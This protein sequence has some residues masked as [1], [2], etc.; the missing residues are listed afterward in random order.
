MYDA[1]VE[2]GE[3]G[4]VPAVGGAYEIAG[5]AL[6]AVNGVAVAHGAFLKVLGGVLI[7]AVHAAV[8]VVINR[9][10][11]DIILVHEVDNRRYSIGM[12]CCV[13]VDFHIKNVTAT[14]HFVIRSF[15]FGFMA[16]AAVVIYRHVIGVG[17]VDFVCDAGKYT[18]ALPVSGGEFAREAFGRSG[19]N[20]I[21]MAEFF[22]VFICT[23]AHVPHNLETQSLCLFAFPVVLA[24]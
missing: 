16:R 4:F 5:N 9:A 15:H 12:M 24:S 17:I 22:A 2:F 10:I 21:I 23:A 14:S 3:F 6:Q 20:R 13:T 8:A 7:A 11:T 19:E 18:E 1:V